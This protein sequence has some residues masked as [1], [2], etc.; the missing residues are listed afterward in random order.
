MAIDCAQFEEI[1]HEL[2]RAGTPGFD[3]REDAFAHAE[4][5]PR[6]ASLL[7]KVMALESALDS[8][9][10]QDRS[11]RA[12]AHVEA[13]LLAEFRRQHAEAAYP[14]RNVR[15]TTTTALAMAAALILAIGITVPLWMK[16][17]SNVTGSPVALVAPPNGSAGVASTDETAKGN[18]ASSDFD[19]ATDFV[20]L[21]YADDPR[22]LD[23]GT[24]VRVTLSRS[25]LASFGLP[26]AGMGSSE[27]IP[28]D[29]ALSEDGVPQAIRLVADADLDP[30]N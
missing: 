5:C 14:R 12:P 22:T 10:V 29:I 6:C 18:S 8:L 4:S 27:Q 28:A 30:T 21:P 3:F 15:L 25:A 26:V 1:V 2:E 9:A 11:E 17:K 24:V 23:G 19:Y 20:S 13:A 7:D 16:H